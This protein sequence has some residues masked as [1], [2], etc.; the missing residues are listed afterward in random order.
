[1]NTQINLNPAS[2]Y[3]TATDGK[4]LILLCPG[5][6][7]KFYV[8][9]DKE[10]FLLTTEAGGDYYSVVSKERISYKTLRGYFEVKG[11]IWRKA[12]DALKE[13][14]YLLV[15]K[16]N[17]EPNQPRYSYLG[18]EIEAWIKPGQLKLAET[19][20]YGPEQTSEPR[21][22]FNKKEG[23]ITL[24]SSKVTREWKKTVKLQANGKEYTVKSKSYVPN[25]SGWET[26]AEDQTL[27]CLDL[28]AQ[29]GADLQEYQ[30]FS[31]LSDSDYEEYI[32]PKRSRNV[33]LDHDYFFHSNADG[34]VLRLLANRKE[35]VLPPTY[36]FYNGGNGWRYSI[37]YGKS[38]DK[39]LTWDEVFFRLK[40]EDGKFSVEEINRR[41][42]TKTSE[43]VTQVASKKFIKM[44]DL[45]GEALTEV[46]Y[47]GFTSEIHY[48][49][50]AYEETYESE[51]GYGTRSTYYPGYTGVHTYDYHG[52]TIRTTSGG[53]VQIVDKEGKVLDTLHMFNNWVPKKPWCTVSDSEREE[54]YISSKEGFYSSQLES[55]KAWQSRTVELLKLISDDPTTSA[56]YRVAILLKDFQWRV[57][58]A[59]EDF[60]QAH[61]A[62]RF[63]DLEY[64]SKEIAA[65]ESRL[66]KV[67]K[68]KYQARLA[69]EKADAEAKAKAEAEKRA[70]LE[71]QKAEEERRAEEAYRARLA[72]QEAEEEVEEEVVEESTV[73]GL[74]EAD[75]LA[76]LKAAW[77]CR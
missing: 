54:N 23:T 44:E 70:K 42:F 22:K 20:E 16:F 74:S 43:A 32:K 53:F 21:L 71:A 17:F 15:S 51:D 37:T 50:D 56:L 58:K 38:W 55:V 62:S 29:F 28:Q 13:G 8:D 5:F 72:A 35:Q 26:V 12:A 9:R 19:I 73:E 57:Q 34:L 1:M 47:V 27:A 2:N 76:A 67:D 68:T 36:Y 41:P 3:V 63:S 48:K 40:V 75:Q 11:G 69:K 45:I 49:V 33:A 77:G 6:D 24:Q 39:E 64:L 61:Y 7:Y 31:I 10:F 66:A 14:Y 60:S 25:A 46:P 4:E 52:T 18:L 59:R 65:L 30:Y